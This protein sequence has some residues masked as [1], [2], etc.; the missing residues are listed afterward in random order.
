MQRRGWRPG[1]WPPRRLSPGP[2]LPPAFRRTALLIVAG[3]AAVVVIMGVLFAHHTQPGAL[4]TAVDARMRSGLL[5]F[6][7]FW[8]PVVV[9]GDP[10]P[11]TE[12]AVALLL[13]CLAA[14]RWRGALLVA[15]AVP[16]AVALTELLL[17]PLIHRT[18]WGNL[19]FPSGHTTS[20]FTL[21]TCCAVLLAR[22]LRL[23]LPGALRAL[24][25]TAAYLA[26]AAVAM[27][28]VVLGFHYFTDTV[29][30]VA[31]GV[32]TVLATALVLDR[33]GPP[34]RPAAPAP[35][36]AAARESVPAAAVPGD[37]AGRGGSRGG[38]PGDGG[39]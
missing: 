31:V 7:G 13:L 1:S 36:R 12:M 10:V 34:A 17:K 27:A 28:V 25:A 18:F 3:C 19:E 21:A 24:L 14:R 8:R 15:V 39:H 23:R 35:A 6:G 26:A 38:P 11:G 30:G 2:L 29:A 33:Y 20:V 37:S 4:D 5:R 22:P 9:L 32:G 16:A